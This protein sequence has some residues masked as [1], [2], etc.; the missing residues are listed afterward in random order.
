[1]IDAAF[2]AHGGTRRASPPRC[3]R[4]GTLSI[5]DCPARYR[6]SA[7]VPI[8]SARGDD[9]SEAEHGHARSAC[10]WSL[11]RSAPGNAGLANHRGRVFGVNRCPGGSIT[12][13]KVKPS[14]P[15]RLDLQALAGHDT[16]QDAGLQVDEVHR[17]F[18]MPMCSANGPLRWDEPGISQQITMTI[19]LA[20]SSQAATLFI[21]SYIRHGRGRE[22]S[23]TAG[24]EEGVDGGFTHQQAWAR[25]PTSNIDPCS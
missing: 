3:R 11:S 1:M 13:H 20:L 14:H 5:L 8:A 7:A 9:T 22:P 24:G 2:L 10:R 19:P 6:C 18:I 17:L 4:G 15:R 25:L 23:A 21:G 12:V 16:L